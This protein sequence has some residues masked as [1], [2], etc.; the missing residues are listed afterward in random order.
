MIKKSP[1][2]CVANPIEPHRQLGLTIYRLAHD[3]TF[4]MLADLFGVS[5]VLAENTFNFISASYL[6]QSMRQV[7]HVTLGY[8]IVLLSWTS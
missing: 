4:N 1:T 7:V 5:I 8:V 2:N 6:L 3:C